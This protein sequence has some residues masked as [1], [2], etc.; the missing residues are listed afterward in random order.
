MYTYIVIIGKTDLGAAKLVVS[1]AQHRLADAIGGRAAVGDLVGGRAAG[2]EE[3]VPLDEFVEGVT[4]R[5]SGA[6]DTD[7]LHHARVPKLAAAEVAVKHLQD[8]NFRV[9]VIWSEHI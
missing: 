6:P 2:D 9:T 7:G 3:A 5:V 1:L 4:D 8:K